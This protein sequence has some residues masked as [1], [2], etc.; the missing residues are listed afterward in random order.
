MVEVYQE[1]V[2]GTDTIQ[3]PYR[4]HTDTNERKPGVAGEQAGPAELER[5]S[6][7]KSVRKVI[8]PAIHGDGP[9]VVK[10]F[11]WQVLFPALIMFLRT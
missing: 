3:R 9:H 8:S 2:W 6:C 4:H 10:T 5:A 7:S 11:F 1:Y